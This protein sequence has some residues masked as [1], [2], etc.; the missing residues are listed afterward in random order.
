MISIV[1]PVYRNADTLPPLHARLTAVLGEDA[2]VELIFVDDACPAG[3]GAVLDRLAEGDSRV[4][5][6]RLARNV[7]QHRAIV[8]GLRAARGRI[9]IAMDADL[10]DPPE[11]VPDL[12]AAIDAGHDVVFCGRAG[13]Y[14]SAGRRLTSRIYKRLQ[15]WLTGVPIDAGSYVALRREVVD[16][17][18]AMPAG[19]QTIAAAIGMA[20]G[21]MASLPR[22]RP[23]RPLGRSAYSSRMR[24][25]LALGSLWWIV[26]RRLFG[27]GGRAPAQT[28][29]ADE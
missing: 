17:V 4:R 14:A 22:R 9:V 10:R 12:L 13:A 29:V 18:L 1:V 24:L 20:G 8:E 19:P 23:A 26:K 28:Q 2:G 16:R 25:S 7:G 3:S 5:V 21:H 6:R 11:A 15:R 27:A